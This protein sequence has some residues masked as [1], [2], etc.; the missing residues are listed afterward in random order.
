MKKKKRIWMAIALLVCV[1]CIQGI[2]ATAVTCSAAAVKKTGLVKEKGRFYYYQKGRKLKSKW[3]TIEIKGKRYT[4]YF[5]KDGAAYAG[6]VRYGD[7]IPAVEKIG[8]YTYAF[9]V[10]GR[11]MKGI[12]VIR[13]K[14]YVFAGNGRLNV[15][16]TARLR[17]ASVY[18]ADV[19]RLKGIL[20]RYGAKCRKT[21][22]FPK[23][24]H[25]EGE[26]GLMHWDAFQVGIFKPTGGKAYILGIYPL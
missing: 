24:C 9:D 4:Y 1:C 26:D 11:R 2:A 18:R 22:Y 19:D 10:N 12:Q 16:K 17:K 7:E 8:G 15:Q 21:E 13:E 25:G 20:E 23:G 3:K 14:F 6:K 5:G